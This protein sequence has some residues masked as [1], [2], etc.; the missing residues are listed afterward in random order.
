MFIVQ[1][2]Y[3]YVHSVRFTLNLQYN[4]THLCEGLVLE[5]V[6]V[7]VDKTELADCHQL[8]CVSAD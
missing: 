7:D 6:A 5:V 4:T 2:Y 1:H 8:K 3:A